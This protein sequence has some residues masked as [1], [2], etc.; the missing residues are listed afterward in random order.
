MLLRTKAVYVSNF[1]ENAEYRKETVEYLLSA[2]TFCDAEKATK[3]R[4]EENLRPQEDSIVVVAISNYHALPMNNRRKEQ[5]DKKWFEVQVK[6]NEE[7]GRGKNKVV[8]NVSLW[9]ANNVTHAEELA[10]ESYVSENIFNALKVT[11]VIEMK[12]MEVIA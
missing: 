2:N 11:K 8:T 1:N 7:T 5:D 4:I 10:K 3:I 6:Y 9:A 12:F